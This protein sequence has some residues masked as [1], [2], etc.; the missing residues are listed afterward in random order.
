MPEPLFATRINRFYRSA[1]LMAFVWCMG[2]YERIFSR[3]ARILLIVFLVSMV[4]S[5]FS[6]EGTALFIIMSMLSGALADLIAGTVFLPRLG[7]T[8]RIPRR[9]ICG[10]PLSI[11]YN[12]KNKRKHFP[13]LDLLAEP[14]SM[15]RDFQ[16]TDA[17]EYFS[18]PAGGE[19]D[20]TVRLTPLHRGLCP[21]P[22]AMVESSFPFNIFKHAQRTGEKETLLVHP[23]YREMKSLLMHRS[24]GHGERRALQNNIFTGNHAAGENLNFNGCREYQPGDP[25]RRIH[26]MATAKRNKLVVKEFQQE[27]LPTAAVFLDSFH[28]MQTAGTFS[29]RRL[30]KEAVRVI[31]TDVN[32]DT[33][34]LLSLGASLVYTLISSGVYISHYSWG[35]NVHLCPLNGQPADHLP[36]ILDTFAFAEAERKDPLPQMIDA[37]GKMQRELE[38]LYLVLQRYDDEIHN[39]IAALK[40]RKIQVRCILLSNE[41][42]NGLPPDV[43]HLTIQD[44][45]G[46]QEKA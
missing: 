19:R 46:K 42:F 34:A 36:E 15:G 13:A 5:L 23:A 39:W 30:Y 26:W 6:T 31:T 17:L 8:R 4:F 27:Q 45:L 12:I 21:L 40:A 38:E 1:L 29:W 43:I 35:G 18:I 16:R 25:P 33:E 28:P 2:W 9:G 41:K 10:I 24:N 22:C 14:Y 32:R 44:I 20:I 37:T 7:I 3:P 11:N